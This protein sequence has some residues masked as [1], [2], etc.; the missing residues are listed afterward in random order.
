M[1]PRF[2]FGIT[3]SCTFPPRNFPVF[4]SDFVLDPIIRPHSK[5]PIPN[6]AG[7]LNEVCCLLLPT[8]ASMLLREKIVNTN[9]QIWTLLR[10]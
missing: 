5:S 7:A 3:A 2:L 4:E 6:G 8:S 9:G 1:P 10:R